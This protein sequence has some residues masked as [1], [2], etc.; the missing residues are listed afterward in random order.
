MMVACTS[1]RKGRRGLLAILPE[2]CERQLLS[3]SE[4][5]VWVE[6]EERW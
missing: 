6:F 4:G 1:S 5:V 2:R 3:E